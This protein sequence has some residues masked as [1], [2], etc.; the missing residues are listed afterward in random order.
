MGAT[1]V[2]ITAL[3]LP[4]LVEAIVNLKGR[5]YRMVVLYLGDGQCPELPDGVL[6]HE[7][8]D[9]FATMELAGEFGPR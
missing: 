7:L 1:L 3:V 8:Q 9:H 5:G 4:E 2:V 6:L